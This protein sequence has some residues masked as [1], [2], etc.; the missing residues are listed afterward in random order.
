M[1]LIRLGG[2]TLSDRFSSL[3]EGIKSLLVLLHADAAQ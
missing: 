1:C 2:W 3:F